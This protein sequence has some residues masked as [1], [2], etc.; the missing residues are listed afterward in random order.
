[1]GPVPLTTNSNPSSAAA[2]DAAPT[3]VVEIP[4]GGPRGNAAEIPPGGPRDEA[5]EIPPGGPRGD[6]AE[7]PPGGALGRQ[8]APAAG[9]SVSYV[10]ITLDGLRFTVLKG[11]LL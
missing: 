9:D 6:A 8:Q 11:S 10:E 7:I 5:A 3:A 1:L 2:D 4:P